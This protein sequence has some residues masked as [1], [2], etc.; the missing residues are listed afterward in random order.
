M[1]LHPPKLS[2]KAF[3][4]NSTTQLAQDF[5]LGQQNVPHAP[6]LQRGAPAAVMT[7]NK[8]HMPS[9]PALKPVLSAHL[10]WTQCAAEPP[11][12]SP[13]KPA[14]ACAQSQGARVFAPSPAGSW[15]RQT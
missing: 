10:T 15:A 7:H 6:L 11:H 14:G 4:I 13:G 5:A 2:V 9:F 8:K 12:R 3:S 1:C